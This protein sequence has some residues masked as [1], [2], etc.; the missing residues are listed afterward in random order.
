MARDPRPPVLYLRSFRDD[1]DA[2]ID[3]GGSRAVGLTMELV[4]PPSP[5]EELAELLARFGPVVAI[6]KPGEPLPELGAARLYVPHDRWQRKVLDLMAAAGLVVVR[7]GT[8]PGVLWEIEQALRDVPRQRLVL[9]LMGQGGIAPPIVERLAPVLGPALETILP[10]APARG[11]KAW[12]FRD[13]RRR[14]GGMVGFDPGGRPKAAPLRRWPLAPRE[15]VLYTAFRPSAPPLHHALHDLLAGVHL[16]LPRRAPRNRARA[17]VL[18]TLFGGWGAHWFYLE[19]PRRGWF[20]VA[21]FPI[22]LSFLLAWIDGV[23][24]LWLDRAGFDVRYGAPPSGT[25]APPASA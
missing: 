16:E 13:P 19:R 25:V 12:F 5:E 15:L 1:D 20:Y 23:R 21:T 4:R 8:S 24:F 17:A 10:E 3:D 9:V 7:V 2:H 22:G 18:A 11:L 14:L 6:G